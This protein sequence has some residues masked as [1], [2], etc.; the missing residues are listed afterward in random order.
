MLEN[1][2]SLQLNHGLMEV[3]YVDH[4]TA[5]P[6]PSILTSEVFDHG[7]SLSVSMTAT[8]DTMGNLV[9]GNFMFSSLL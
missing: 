4:Q 2:N 7:Q 5:A 3:G 9:L 8:M 6:L 1:F